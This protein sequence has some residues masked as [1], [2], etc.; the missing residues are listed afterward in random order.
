MPRRGA[1][2]RLTLDYEARFIRRRTLSTD[3]AESPLVDLPDT[4]S[5]DD[6]DT[7]ETASEAGLP[8]VARACLDPPSLLPLGRFGPLRPHAEAELTINVS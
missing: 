3:A 4:V 2:D 1:A 6:G 7:L 8:V 5:P